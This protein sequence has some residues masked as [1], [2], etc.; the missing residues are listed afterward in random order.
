MERPDYTREIF[1]N[2]TLNLNGIRAI[3]YDMDYTLIHY[4]MDVWESL[5]YSYG[6]ERLAAE[7]WPL[8][9]LTFDPRLV[10]RG[11]VIDTEHGNVVKANRFGYI[12]RA[13]HGTH[14]LPF[15]TQRRIYQRTLVDLNESRWIFLNTLFSISAACLYMQ[16]VE[17]LDRGQLGNRTGYADLYRFVRQSL[18]EAHMEGRLKAE[19]IADPERFVDFDPEM[20]RAVLDQK[21]AGKKILLITNSDWAYTAPMLACVFD[22]FLP[23][24]MT[25]RDLFDIAIVSARKPDFFTFRMPAFEVVNDEGMLRE[26]RGPLRSGHVYLGGNAPLVEQ[27]LGLQGEEILYVGDHIFADVNVTKSILRWRTALVLREIEEETA[28]LQ[29][30]ADHHEELDR[31][32]R[33]KERLEAD[34]ARLRLELQR[35]QHARDVREDSAPERIE[36]QMTALH[37]QLNDLD[38]RIAPMAQKL[39]TLLNPHWGLLMR[40]GADKSHMARQVERYADIYTG[41]VSNFLYATPFGFLRSRRGSL[42]HDSREMPR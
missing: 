10:M 35:I 42:P 31:L 32:M 33:E 27:S 36:R 30:Y 3:G 20:P 23:D 13:F 2:R 26:H 5:A 19:I 21:D 12:K 1:C 34:Q 40:T 17:M 24:H 11:L 29:S 9:G 38:G 37:Q 22:P 28:A 18:D 16:L 4:R 25:W 8:D 14:P 41:R 6:K 15:E 39:A 7:G